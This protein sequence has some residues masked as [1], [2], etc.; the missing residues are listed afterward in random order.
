MPKI[1]LTAGRSSLKLKDKEVDKESNMLARKPI[2]E[3]PGQEKGSG[4]QLLFGLIILVC[5]F[6]ALRSIDNGRKID[7]YLDKAL[8][9]QE[10][11]NHKAASEITLNSIER[12]NK[13]EI[14][15]A[16]NIGEICATVKPEPEN[17]PLKKNSARA[18]QLVTEGKR[19]HKIALYTGAY[20]HIRDGVSL[21]L[22]RLVKYLLEEGHEVLVLAPTTP[23]P[24]IDHQG[25]LQPVPS[26][27]F[28]GRSDYR[29]STYLTNN[30]KRQLLEFEPD[31]V[32]VATPDLVG[33]QVQSWAQTNEIPAVCSFHTHFTSYLSYYNLGF[34][35]GF[36]WDLLR[37]FYQNCNQTYVPSYG[38]ANELKEHG[39][40][41]G[42]LLWTRGVNTDIYSPE[43]RC[44]A[45]RE[46]LHIEDDEPV[47]LIACRLVWEKGLQVYVDVIKRLEAA[48]IK[49][50]SVVAGDGPARAKMQQLLPNTV[51]LGLQTAQQLSCTYA[52]SD[53]YLFPSHTETFG[54]T[55]LEAMASGLPVVVANA[56]GPAMMVTHGVNG[57]MAT[58]SDSEEF[59]KYT[60]Q[61]VLN[62]EL[63][64]N[65]S[66]SGRN[67]AH[68]KFHW[69]EVFAN[70]VNY[71]DGLYATD[72]SS[73]VLRTI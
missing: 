35:E 12:E 7:S 19:K 21:T 67:I 55:T 68:K 61:L 23:K 56:S 36:T 5:T 11:G 59:Y 24:V 30:I 1:W 18:L 40:K 47:I 41:D 2:K 16:L 22:N 72:D 45:L 50:R 38:I 32:H 10:I 49:H 17:K 46:E 58:P 43:R 15:P 44:S 25:T 14:A 62:P 34:L 63:R 51:F 29:L 13:G 73:S 65:M 4:T 31:I 53:V 70:L 66:E 60:E 57:F 3:N 71:Y 27:S 42:L 28:P 69:S 52:S 39:V 54:V 6:L 48:G 26:I 64:Q 20:N 8:L 37:K 9:R 33:F